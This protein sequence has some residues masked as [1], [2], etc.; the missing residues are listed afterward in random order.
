MFWIITLL[1]SL[2]SHPFAV[3]A[4]A[5]SPA[6]SS[7]KSVNQADEIER[8]SQSYPFN[9]DGEISVSNINGSITIEAWDSPQV[10]LE[11]EKLASSVDRLQDLQ[12]EVAASLD[13][14]EVKSRYIKKDQYRKSYGKLHVNMSLKVPREAVL[15]RIK[16]V[17]G[18]ISIVGTTGG[19]DV[20]SVNGEV[21]LRNVGGD[22]RASS[23]NGRVEADLGRGSEPARLSSVNGTVFVEVLDP[24]QF[25]KLRASTVNGMIKNDFDLPVVK[26]KFGSGSN[27]AI[28]GP[29]GSRDV[30]LSSVNG[31]IEIVRSGQRL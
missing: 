11:Y 31:T 19:V 14:F 21:R 29:A 7:T 18:D 6:I 28:E 3:D 23:V 16:D 12:V 5:F 22:I 24:R 8:F 30:K 4:S 27:L 15:K 2:V 20:S 13:N 17:N 26:K 9:S 25:A 10:L 1:L